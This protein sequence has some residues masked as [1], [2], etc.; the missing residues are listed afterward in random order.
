MT[1]SIAEEA[2]ETIPEEAAE[3]IA[4]KAA[5]TIAE[6]VAEKATETEEA[7]AE[8]TAE[9]V[10]EEMA[11]YVT[12]EMAEIEIITVKMAETEEVVKS[13]EIF[14]DFSGGYPPTKINGLK[15][16][17]FFSCIEPFS[18]LL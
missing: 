14:W 4:E 17:L 10:A 6:E 12:D 3:T 9:T 15:W 7:V 18:L 16:T 13:V 2:A 8:V 11:E 5:E 1:E